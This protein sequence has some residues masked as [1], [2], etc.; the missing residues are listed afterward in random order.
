MPRL[1][2]FGCSYA[3]GQGLADCQSKKIS[4]LSFDSKKPSQLGWAKQLSDKLKTELIN[5]SYPGSS[6][7][8]ILC[9]I[10]QFDFK[11]D[12]VV[13][14]MW[15]HYLR[16][17]LFTRF[18][19]F[20]TF[21]RRIGAWKNTG[22]SRKWIAQM[23]ERDYSM[24]S[25]IYLQHASLYLN[26]KDIRYIHYPAS[27]NE[28]KEFEFPNIHVDNLYMDGIEWVDYALDN[29]HPGPTTNTKLAEKIFK[30]LNE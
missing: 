24:R 29:S 16:D 25:W 1:I 13:V 22:L 23:S 4:G 2:V 6:N 18:F 3:Y 28:L 14:I 5:K 21:R 15:S 27:P 17:M 20:L 10:L 7:L 11:T 12:D 30:I 19:K 8:E 9:E 26:S